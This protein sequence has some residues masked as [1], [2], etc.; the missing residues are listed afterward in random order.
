MQRYYVYVHRN[1]SDGQVFYVGKGSW[2]PK[3]AYGRAF[4]HENRNIIW[5]R[6]VAKHGINVEVIAEFMSE[7]DAFSFERELIAA[8]GRKDVGG[9]LCNLTDG[10]EG[11]CGRVVSESTKQKRRELLKTNHPMTGRC[12][13]LH[14]N[15]GKKLSQEM[16]QYI[17]SK[18]RGSK[19]PMYGKHH[20]E[21]TKRKL[22]DAIRINHPR[23]RQVINDA[24]G[25]VYPS[26]REASRQL[27]IN[28]NTLKA[29]LAGRCA[30]DT[31]L[32]FA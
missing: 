14:H 32:R 21:E 29:K 30:N 18:V 19:H 3:K 2:T 22:S 16:K 31:T 23:A 25:V 12:G 15:Y 1:P 8:N 7:D 4:S 20:S 13:E 10:G 5:L 11:A 6:T 26:A 28:P 9:K 27:S 24:T 17:S